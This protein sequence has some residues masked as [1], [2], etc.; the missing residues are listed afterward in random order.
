MPASQILVVDDEADIRDMVQEILTEEGYQ[1]QV[2]GSAAEARSA[3]RQGEPDL[4]LHDIWM[5]DM[6]GI[7]LL[8]EWTREQRLPFPVVMMCV[9]SRVYVCPCVRVCVRACVCAC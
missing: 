7:S 6:D 1:V 3:R 9:H 8:K 2:A 4:V 5:T